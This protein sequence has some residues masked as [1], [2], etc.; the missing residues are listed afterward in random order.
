M[1]I[2]TRTT[3]TFEMPKEYAAAVEF[4]KADTNNEYLKSTNSRTISFRK[5]EIQVIKLKEPQT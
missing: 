4:E 1:I 5:I 2:D 3:I